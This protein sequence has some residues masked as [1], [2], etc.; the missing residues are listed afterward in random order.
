[1][2]LRAVGIGAPRIHKNRFMPLMLAIGTLLSLTLPAA[3]NEPA[4]AW[5]KISDRNGIEVFVSY[6]ETSRLKTFRGIT[7]MELPD[8]FAMLALYNDI[9]AFPMWLHMIDGAELINERH[10]TDRDLRFT[11]SLPWPLMDR[12]V[13]LTSKLA[14]VVNINEESVTAYLEGDSSMAEPNEDYVR[15]PELHGAFSF[16]RLAPDVVEATFQ[17]SADLGGYLPMW[18]V[19]FAFR[20]IPYFT[21]EKMRRIVKKEEYQNHYYDYLPLFGPGRPA[22]LPQPKSWVYGTSLDDDTE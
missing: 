22:D 17:I 20:D 13:Y 7:T 16:R 14:Y 21:L 8:E 19:N 11:I 1:M 10:P 6:S 5:R 3:A 18:V 4:E 12:E 9:D 2:L 15:L